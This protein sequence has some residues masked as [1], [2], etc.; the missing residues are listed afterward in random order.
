M[1]HHQ[2][3]WVLLASIT[4][5]TLV[6]IGIVADGALRS[7]RRVDGRQEFQSMVYGLGL[8]STLNLDQCQFA[9]DPRLGLVCSHFVGPIPGGTF[10][11]P[12]HAGS[13]TNY[14]SLLPSPKNSLDL[15]EHAASR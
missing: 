12:K 11:C 3:E 9:F 15:S 8:G 4:I 1:K 5:S 6:A 14:P 10:L 13:I 7:E 2:C